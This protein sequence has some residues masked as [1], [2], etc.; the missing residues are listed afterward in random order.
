MDA[1]NVTVS[2]EHPG[3]G[4]YGAR[5]T[6]F[7]GG[8][9]VAVYRI[10]LRNVE[11]LHANIT[12]SVLPSEHHRQLAD[13]ICGHCPECQDTRMVQRP[14]PG[15][16]RDWTEHCPVCKPKLDAAEAERKGWGKA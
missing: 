16:V 1:Q 7:D 15:G 2:I 6:V 11:A 4:P 14:G 9:V 5:L 3:M 13:A 8:T 12:T 10:D